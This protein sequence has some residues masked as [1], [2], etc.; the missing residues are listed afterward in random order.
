MRSRRWV[1]A[2]RRGPGGLRAAPRRARVVLKGQRRWLGRDQP[3]PRLS[4]DLNPS[5]LPPSSLFPISSALHLS[6]PSISALLPT[7]ALPSS[8]LHPPFP[9]CPPS[10][11]QPLLTPISPLPISPCPR[12]LS[13][14]SLPS[15][16]SFLCSHLPSAPSSLC[17]PAL[18][19]SSLCPHVPLVP[20][21]RRVTVTTGRSTRG[22]SVSSSR[23]LPSAVAAFGCLSSSPAGRNR[24]LLPLQ[25]LY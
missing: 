15:S 4:L 18:A 8:T 22:C 14:P 6:S 11:P 5:P 24:G 23:N 20:I 3:G 21:S 16:P 17:L 25:R 7:L 19:P 2:E 1:G 10:L 13:T 12:L 9:L